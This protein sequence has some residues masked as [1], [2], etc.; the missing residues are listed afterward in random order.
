MFSARSLT[1]LEFLETCTREWRLRFESADSLF[2]IM[3]L[4]FL[5]AILV[6]LL[7]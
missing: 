3:Q 1:F 5:T 4:V 6:S 2:D 7:F